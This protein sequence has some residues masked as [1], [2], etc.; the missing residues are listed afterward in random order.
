[1]HT[2]VLNGLHPPSSLLLVL[3]THALAL[4]S[5]CEQVLVYGLLFPITGLENSLLPGMIES[6]Q[7]SMEGTPDT[8]TCSLGLEHVSI[9][10]HKLTARQT[11]AGVLQ[12]A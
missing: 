10:W 1:M 2:P 9:A 5:C 6:E 8:Y 3:V 4:Y 12:G 7:D 11:V